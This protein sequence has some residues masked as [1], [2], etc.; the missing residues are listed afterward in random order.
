MPELSTLAQKIY[1]LIEPFLPATGGGD[2]GNGATWGFPAAMHGIDQPGLDSW[3]DEFDN[4]SPDLATRGWTVIN[5]STGV[6]LTRNGA[7]G[8]AGLT[9][10]K[11]NSEI[12][13]SSLLVQI[14]AGPGVL[15]YKDAPAGNAVYAMRARLFSLQATEL[16]EQSQLLMCMFLADQRAASY[17]TNLAN[18]LQLGIYRNTGA[19]HVYATQVTTF[20]GYQ[21]LNNAEIPTDWAGDMF[22]MESGANPVPMDSYDY[23]GATRLVATRNSLGAGSTPLQMGAMLNTPTQQLPN[24]ALIDFY[25]RRA[26]SA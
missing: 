10:G 6:L 5:S 13:N 16:G 25:R 8:A 21:D 2:A 9:A 14:Q 18:T 20:G 17:P 15:L 11:Y 19:L 12:V 23:R 22:V 24:Y 26:V 4:G 1:D 7:I 3:D